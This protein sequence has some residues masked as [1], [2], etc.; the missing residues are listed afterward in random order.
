M[1]KRNGV[2]PLQELELVRENVSYHGYK[3]VSEKRLGVIAFIHGI[4]EHFGRYKELSEY[5][6]KQGYSVYGVDL[7]GHGKSPGIRG[8]V[9]RRSDLYKLIDTFIDYV[10]REEMGSPIFLMG[11]SMGGNITLSYRIARDRA[12][13][14]GYIASS[15]WIRL[16]K[17][18]TMLAYGLSIVASVILPEKQLKS[19]VKREKAFHPGSLIPP[20]AK[21]DKLCHPF[22]TPGTIVGCLKWA[23]IILKETDIDRPPILLMHGTRDGICSVEG[24]REFA[25]AAGKLC[26]YREWEGLRHDMINEECRKDI[27]DEILTWLELNRL[28]G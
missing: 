8:H 6:A 14:K 7:P 16:V 21:P 26:T 28:R 5:M 3:A 22:I 10:A 2:K 20:S 19:G 12:S 27:A 11:H 25:A 24:S 23:K 9:G 1:D 18:P 15:P 13:V 4:G 17:P